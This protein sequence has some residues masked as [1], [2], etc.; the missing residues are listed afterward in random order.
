MQ[1]FISLSKKIYGLDDDVEVV[2][3]T[4][5]YEF[6]GPG[7][8]SQIVQ[9]PDGPLTY[10][11]VRGPKLNLRTDLTPYVP[12]AADLLADAQK[13]QIETI[14]RDCA[15]TI[16][17]GFTSS[18]LGTVYTYPSKDLD[19]MNLLGLQ[20][21]SLD[22]SNPTTWSTKFWCADANGVW[23]LRVHTTAQIQ[24]VFLDGVAYKLACIVQNKALATQVMAITDTTA[25]GIASM[26]AIVWV[27]P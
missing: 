3:I 24:Q 13:T 10:P 1:Y 4:G 12:T 7:T 20:S 8:P 22:P 6:F 9:G 21:A 19:Q 16:Y 11:A 23:D 14:S 26:Q 2:P 27:K 25:V 5:G 17:A 15:D 18:A